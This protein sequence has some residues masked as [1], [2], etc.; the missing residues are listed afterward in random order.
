MTPGFVT[1]DFRAVVT[2]IAEAI[3]SA[4]RSAAPTEIRLYQAAFGDEVPVA[5]NRSV[6]AYNRNP[7]VVRRGESERHLAMNRTMHVLGFH[8]DGTVQ[9]LLSLFGV[10]A[11]CVGNALDKFDGDN[12]G[13]AA[14]HAEQQLRAAGAPDPVAIFAQAT[15]GDI[16]PHFH[17]PGD[18][19]RRKQI[20]GAAEYAYA[21]RNGR[22]RVRAR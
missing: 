12:K 17:G 10:H 11:T 21:E 19:E 3:V 18:W 13:Y 15:A 8:R 1:P 6:R 22:H 4:W 20:R 7:D 16:S 5:W 14:A 2:A 9:A